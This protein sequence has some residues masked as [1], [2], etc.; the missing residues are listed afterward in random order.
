MRMMASVPSGLPDPADHTQTWWEGEP[1]FY[2]WWQWMHAEG[3]GLGKI[4][5]D[6]RIIAR[7]AEAIPTTAVI[8]RLAAL[9]P[10]IEVGAGG[11]YWARLIQDVGG[12]MIATDAATPGNNGWYRDL[13][14]G[15]TFKR[16]PLVT[17]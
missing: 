16:L 13:T 1:A 11:G 14:L 10:I 7:Y 8:R 4:N 2:A 15:Q 9:G 17:L 5:D 3:H 6:Y 12:D